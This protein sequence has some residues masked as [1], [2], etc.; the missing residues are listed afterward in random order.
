MRRC[1]IPNGAAG[2]AALALVATLP[3]AIPVPWAAIGTIFPGAGQIEFFNSPVQNQRWYLLFGAIATGVLLAAEAP[4]VTRQV[5]KCTALPLMLLA[6]PLIQA[7][8]VHVTDAE[9][10][11]LL[12]RASM[13]IIFTAAALSPTSPVQLSRRFFILMLFSAPL[14]AI[15]LLQAAGVNLLPYS[16]I[17]PGTSE[18][19]TGK[20]LVSS[21][22]GHPNYMASY[23]APLIPLGFI[24][25]SLFWNGR[26][27]LAVLALGITCF[28]LLVL[29]LAGTRGPFLAGAAGILFA[30]IL[31]P[32]FRRN[33]K[34]TVAVGAVLLCTA[35][36]S[37]CLISAGAGESNVFA[38]LSASKEIA[39]RLFYWNVALIQWEDHPWLGAGLGAFNQQFWNTITT[40]S[41]T[42]PAGEWHFA[43]TQLVRGVAPGDLHNDHL[44]ILVEQGILGYALWAAMWMLIIARTFTMRAP[45]APRQLI[46]QKTMALALVVVGIDEFFFF[47]TH[48][49]CSGALFAYLLGL[50]VNVTTHIDLS[51]EHPV[52][53]LQSPPGPIQDPCLYHE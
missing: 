48:L 34:V 52:N 26:K 38:R 22:F 24:T 31:T 8:V 49:P 17:L 29:I 30:A 45:F 51:Q 15:A 5:C 35:L 28:L 12:L 23:L 47:P 13:V 1:P 42:G 4:V 33:R 2:L 32:P 9:P 53:P 21:T 16:D 27:A 40:M 46:I 41:A 25:S 14:A 3:Y 44:Q 7:G 19:V 6:W 18:A 50:W 43:L 10:H 11:R 37:F 39:T 20:L 36:I